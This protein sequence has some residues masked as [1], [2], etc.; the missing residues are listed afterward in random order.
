M[1]LG[2]TGAVLLAGLHLY[3]VDI[4]AEVGRLQTATG[5]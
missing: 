1:E 4:E 5:A 3:A 2:R